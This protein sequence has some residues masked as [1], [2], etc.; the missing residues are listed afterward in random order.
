MKSKALRADG[1]LFVFMDLSLT[2][3]V[4]NAFDMGKGA[5]TFSAS[6]CFTSRFG[7]TK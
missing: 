3:L 6:L 4:L 5:A 2:V 7:R 1:A